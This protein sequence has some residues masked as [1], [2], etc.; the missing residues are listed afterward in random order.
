MLRDGAGNA[1]MRRFH[2]LGDLAPRD[3]VSRGIITVLRERGENKAL[4]DLSAIPPER[5]RSRFPRILE[6]LKGFGIDILHESIPVRPSAHYSIGGVKTD[7]LARTSLP[8]LFAAGEVAS[9]GLH[10]A[11]RLASNSI[12][13]GL[14]F[15]HRA[16]HAAREEAGAIPMPQPFSVESPPPAPG[17]KPAAIDL[18]DLAHSLKSLLWQKVGLER[19]GSELV[20]ALKQIQSWVPYVLGSDFYEVPSWTVQNM[21]LTSCLLTLAALRREESRGVHYRTDFPRRDDAHWRR[22]QTLTQDDLRGAARDG[23]PG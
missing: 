17:P 2:P 5:I 12:L 4:L 13:E 16:G 1:F 15:G 11:N 8:G 23:L 7:L 22:H 21:I 3:V 20:A 14:V 19:N 9:T 18:N 10:G 6:I